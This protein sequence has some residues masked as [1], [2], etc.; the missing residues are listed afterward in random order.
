MPTEA[1]RQIGPSAHEIQPAVVML[2]HYVPKVQ[3][4]C[5]FLTGSAAEIARELMGKIRAAS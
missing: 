2:R 4:S 1:W 3:G 5:Q